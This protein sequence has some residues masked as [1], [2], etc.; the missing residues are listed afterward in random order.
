MKKVSGGITAARGFLAAGVHCGI[1]KNKQLDLALVLSEQEGPVAG[2]F[3]TNRVAAA[4]VLLDRAYLRKGLARALIVNSG[5]A[6]ACTGA[7]GILAAEAMA[8][9]LPA[10]SARCPIKSLSDRQG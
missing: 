3:T 1:K 5:N 10:I 4:P 8:W 2:L 6:N 7:E 9:R